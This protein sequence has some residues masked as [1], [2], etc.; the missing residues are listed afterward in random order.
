MD[1]RRT[2]AI[3]IG[4]SGI[5][6]ALLDAKGEIVAGPK[7]VPTPKPTAAPELVTELIRNAAEGLPGFDRVSVG[8]P[9]A[10]RDGRVKTAPNLGT[11]LWAGFDLQSA[12][13]EIWGK[14]VRVMNDADVQGYGAIQGK[15][16]EMVLTLGT[17]AGTAIF[18][19]GRIVPHLE[20]AHH[21]VAGGK[22]YDEYIGRAALE[23]KGKKTWNKRV[24]KVIGILRTVVNFDHLYIGGGNAKKLTL[25]LPDDVST[26]P[27]VDGLLG[28]IRLW[29]AE[30]ARRPARRG[31]RPRV[32]AAPAPPPAPAPVAARRRGR[33]R[34]VA[35]AVEAAVA[36]AAPRRRRA[37]SEPS[38]PRGRPRRR[39]PSP[40]A[41]GRTL[42]AAQP[43]TAVDFAVPAG[44][45]DCHVHVF[46]T[47]AAFPFAER[48][49]YTPP[50]AGADELLA[51]QN[52]LH[53]D[54]VVIV[55]PSVYGT[56]NSC[57]LDGIRRLGSRARGVAVIDDATP[58]EALDAMHRAGIRGVRVNLATAGENDPEIARRNLRRAVE[59]VARLGWHVQ[60]Y[61]GLD[62]VAALHDEVMGLAVPIVFDH[63][64]GAQAALGTGQ[65]GF[66]QLLAQ[67]EA[68][69]AY[70]KVS[71]HYRSSQQAPAYADVA[72]LA[73]ALIAA[74]PDRIVWGTDWPHPAH[75]ASPERALTEVAP[76]YDIDDGLALNQLPLWTPDTDTLRKILVDNPARLYGF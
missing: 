43:R 56:D 33:P 31:R 67:V 22:T 26:V 55:Q 13:S 16:V 51:L 25:A 14:P 11:E 69:K 47:V 74:N 75:P 38:R 4:G 70:V 10:V 72:P 52:A 39:A 30:E 49:G 48:R 20:L 61:T 68:G 45:C 21:P 27:N 19:D 5:K 35:A 3:D 62:V 41:H 7:R 44:A 2:L 53:L 40:D 63:F 34:Q 58:D 29:D 36:P 17:G 64:G 24:A 50:P 12:L 54:R 15:G 28:G 60:V 8:F 73:R 6:L 57:T 66:A 32:A 76:F 46:G 42:I 71:G 18:S 65:P 9:G 23:K 37:R 59:R 1:E